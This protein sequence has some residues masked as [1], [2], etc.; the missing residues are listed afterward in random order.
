[1]AVL[2]EEASDD[3]EIDVGGVQRSLQT[4][5]DAVELVNELVRAQVSNASGRERAPGDRTVR[6]LFLLLLPPARQRD[7]FLS[8]ARKSNS[9]PRLR[10]LFGAPPYPFLQAGEAA[11]LRAGGLA[12]GRVNM[13]FESSTIDSWQTFGSGQ[14]VDA[15][16]RKY[17]LLQSG[18][19]SNPLPGVDLIESGD[20]FPLTVKIPRQRR[21][22]AAVPFPSLGE[23][24]RV[25]ETP[26]LRAARRL[27]GGRSVALRV[28]GVK[29]RGANARTALLRCKRVGD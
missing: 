6:G 13:A 1:M 10:H 8:V 18:D 15:A 28:L 27:E 14:M 22:Q 7:V 17:K 19:A 26:Q 2:F 20:E 25:S 23:V 3:D 29:P 5:G 11:L 21:R 9:W 12:V 4:V 24:V 16:L